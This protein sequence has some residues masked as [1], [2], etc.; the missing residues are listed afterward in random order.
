MQAQSVHVILYREDDYYIAHCLEFDLIAQGDDPGE[1]FKNLL[2]AI[3]L[4]AVYAL[5]SGDPGILF[6]PAP[7]EYWRMLSAAQGYTPPNGW[8]LPKIVSRV[9]CALVTEL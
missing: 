3:D 1:A 6:N 9:D 7:V 8:S 4:Q 5:E 2:D